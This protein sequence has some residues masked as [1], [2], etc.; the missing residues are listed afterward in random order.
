METLIF[1]FAIERIES[2]LACIVYV[3]WHS[4]PTPS[5]SRQHYTYS[6]VDSYS[7]MQVYQ[8]RSHNC[9]SGYARASVSCNVAVFQLHT[10]FCLL[11]MHAWKESD[12]I[13]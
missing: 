8:E 10:T 1:T 5:L 2:E 3:R 4:S 12:G 9:V 6:V 13:M 11:R 7:R